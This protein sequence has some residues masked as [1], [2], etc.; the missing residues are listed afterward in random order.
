MLQKCSKALL[1]T[2][3][4][5]F[6]DAYKELA[7]EAEV[8]L[9][10]EKEWNLRYRLS[11]DVV[12]L[13]AKYFEKLN[14]TYYPEAVL[15]LKEGESPFPYIQKGITRFIFD[16]KNRNELLCAFYKPEKVF[17]SVK[18]K[19]VDAIIKASGVT[20]FCYGD[21]DFDFALDRFKYRGKFIYLQDS[22][23]KYIAEWLLNGHKD[24]S[25]RMILCNL[26][27]KFGKDFMCDIDRYGN[28]GGKN[29]Q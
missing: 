15:I 26:R 5:S 2:D 1:L 28:A 25:R 16:Y 7:L 29:E 9:M 4:Q 6:A 24:N 18:G 21:Y 11:A 23:K 3:V 14:S 20:R 17:V 19:S 8:S 27:K 13:G 22:A 12:I 10:V